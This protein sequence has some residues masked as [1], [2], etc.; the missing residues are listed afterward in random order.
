MLANTIQSIKIYLALLIAMII[1][2]TSMA[3]SHVTMSL[4]NIKANMNTIEYD[5][6][7]INDGNSTLKLGAC[8]YGI[9]YDND[10]ANGGDIYFSYLDNSK[11]Q[12][13]QSLT[14]FSTSISKAGKP[15]QARMTNTI[16][17]RESAPLLNPNIPYKIGRFRLT[18]TV[19]WK[20]N[21]NPHFTLH[22]TT[23]VGLTTTQVIVYVNDEKIS[24]V[25]SPKSNTVSTEVETSP[26]LNEIKQSTNNQSEG[27]ALM[28]DKNFIKVYPN[29]AFETLNIDFNAKQNS[30][31]FINIM[32]MPGRMVKQIQLNVTEGMN[33]LNLDLSE[34]NKGIYTITIVDDK[35]VNYS[36]TFSKH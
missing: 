10:I 15:T 18:N 14:N 32:D 17:R 3:Q 23:T 8:S 36:Q 22:E 30:R 7:I 25:L 11:E 12:A 19:S 20:Q 33:T 16:G 34:L 4:K 31:L 6:Y 24:T 28:S 21:S 27:N 35:L 9:N 1:T 2:N 5:L 29:P 13:L 26:L